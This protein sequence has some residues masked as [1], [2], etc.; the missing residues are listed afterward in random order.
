MIILLILIECVLSV[1]NALVLATL[2]AHLEPKYRK[3]ALTYGILGAYCFRFIS[4]FLLTELLQYQWLRLIAGAYL[5]FLVWKFYFG[6]KNDNTSNQE[7]SF[8]HTVMLVE[9]TDIAFSLDNIFV[10]VGMSQKLIMVFIAAIFGIAF[11]RIA[12]NIFVFL[13]KKWPR[14]EDLAYGLIAWAGVRLMI[15]AL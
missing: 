11:M 4:L 7:K 5:L 10:A 15:G 8:W 9:L 13:I 6:F 12:A 2:V 1:D 3:R 14:L